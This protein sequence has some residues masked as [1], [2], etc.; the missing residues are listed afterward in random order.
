MVII[1]IIDLA[2]RGEFRGGYFKLSVLNKIMYRIHYY[3]FRLNWFNADD[4]L[5]NDSTNTTVDCMDKWTTH[6]APRWW[7]R[8]ALPLPHPPGI[9]KF[10]AHRLEPNQWAPFQKKPWGMDCM[11]GGQRTSSVSCKWWI[12]GGPNCPKVERDLVGEGVIAPTLL[13]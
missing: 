2:L 10:S 12:D 3:P 8:S 13:D 9:S 1:I 11:R 4:K 5:I 7:S 6:Q